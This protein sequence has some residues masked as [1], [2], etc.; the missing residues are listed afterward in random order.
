MESWEL[1]QM[2]SLPLEVKILKTQ[3]RIREWYEAWEGNIYVSFS[4][5]KDSTV[6]LKLVRELYPDVE[7]A[8]VNT[9]LE[10]PEIVRFVNTKENITWLKPDITF[11]KVIEKYGYPVV[12]KEQSFRARKVRNM[13]LTPV[14][15]SECIRKLGKWTTLLDAPF[16]VSEQCCDVMK[17]RP[18]KKYE[19]RFGLKMI[20]GE[21]AGES[22]GRQQQWNK[23][24]CNAFELVRPKSTPMGFWTEQD[25]LEYL[26]RFNEP[27]ST[28]YGEIIPSLKGLITTGESRTGCMWCMF[29]VHLEKGENRFQKMSRTHPKQY[30]YCINKM[31][32]GEVLDYIGVDYRVNNL[33]G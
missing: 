13:N 24:G 21:M 18:F 2:Q 17:K 30:D 31:G 16:Q 25:V 19:K 7:G 10:Y 33:F 1:K 26:V 27:Y 3:Q 4:G 32:L 5:G 12:S 20:T 23:N 8:F 6:L 14:Y 28:V 15:E 9:G 11:N 22:Y 29:G